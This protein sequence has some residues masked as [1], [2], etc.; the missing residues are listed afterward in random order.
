[1]R[2]EGRDRE[3]LAAFLLSL[4]TRRIADPKLHEAIETVPR[5][6]FLPDGIENAY[7][8]RS[9]PID[10]GETM[11]GALFAVRLVSALEIEADHR[12]LEIGT[13]SGYVTALMARLCAHV[14]SF[15]RYRRLV[16]AASRRLKL[17]GVSNIS[18]FL[19]DG[20][21]GF[22]AGAPF[23]RAIVHAAFPT[24]PRLFLDQIR[25]H[26]VLICALGEEGGEQALVRLRKVG[27]RFEREDLGPV[28]YQP[29]AFGTAEML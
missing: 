28:R 29:L 13:G 23:D 5:R 22:A 20:S 27:S 6:F 2:S 19:E 16:E 12:V 14:T 24:V 11:P 21:D 9:A 3:D 17:V 4:R 18:L 8:D 25:P 26:G 7:E 10:C 1:M 15:D